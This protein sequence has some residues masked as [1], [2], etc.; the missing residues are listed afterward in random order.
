MSIY[1]EILEVYYGFDRTIASFQSATGMRCPPGCSLC[2]R[3]W[4]VETTVMELLPLAREIYLREEDEMIMSA[5]FEKDQRH[6][7]SCVLIKN[8]LTKGEA[9]ACGYYKFRPL[10]CRL[11]GFASRRN[12]RG[13]IELMTCRVIKE[14]AP[15][16]VKR[17]EI[18]LLQ[19]L[20]L[21]VYQDA[22][23]RISYMKPNTGSRML[24]INNALKEAI[25]SLYWSRPPKGQRFRKAA[26]F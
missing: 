13:G 23:M 14:N 22:F 18:A 3:G 21:P 11:F 19:G 26:G 10:V 12:K 4:P 25:E 24:P 15:A 1:D 8:V 5:I 6:D 7:P 17:A 20:S 16:E 2:C 9:G